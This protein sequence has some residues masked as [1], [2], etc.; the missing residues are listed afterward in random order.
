MNRS[1]MDTRIRRSIR[2]LSM[3]VPLSAVLALVATGLGVAATSAR[4]PAVGYRLSAQL[5]VAQE[6]P[7]VTAPAAAKGHFDALLVRSGTRGVGAS[8][9][10][11]S[12]CTFKTPPR[13][14]LPN[15]IVC[16]GGLVV[17][18]PRVAGVHWLLAWRLSFS[19]L[20]GPATAAH[21]HLGVQ[22]QA[23]A[24]S[25]P[26]CGPCSSPNRGVASVTPAQATALLHGG[27]YVNVHT[28]QNPGGEIRG[29][30]SS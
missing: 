8:G 18:L 24:V 22:G 20:S 11:P 10:L 17:T 23:G 27:T 6:V 5:T 19:G 4:A 7:A 2:R 12:G 13:S 21:V 14:G 26:L 30:V 1:E 28:A 9:P 15:R 25:I 16:N 3:L 29:Q